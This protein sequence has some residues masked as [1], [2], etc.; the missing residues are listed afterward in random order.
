M[1]SEGDLVG[2]TDMERE[3]RRDWWLALLA[4]GEALN[5]EFVAS[6]RT[7]QHK[8]SDIMTAPVITV[9]ETAPLAEVAGLLAAH[10][11]KRTPVIRDGRIVGIVSRAD[12]LRTLVKE[13]GRT[14]LPRAPRPPA[15]KSNG[16]ARAP[17]G[18]GV[19]E[20]KAGPLLAADLRALGD[21]FKRRELQQ[22]EEARRAAIE[23]SRRK[24][25]ELLDQRLSDATWRRTLH[26]ARQIAENGGKEFMLLRFPSELC[27]DGGRAVNVPDPDWPKTL[28]GEAAE[29]YALWQRDLMP[30][31]FKLGAWVL[32]FPGGVPGDIGLFLSWHE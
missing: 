27:S 10:R 19:A 8:A 3:A 16:A 20:A 26:N 25:K 18:N 21:D 23:E 12:L 24:V 11:I 1:V 7:M 5:P 31:G 17:T 2:R 4:E 22:Q 9:G 28:R 15:S 13:P 32:E 14:V 6:L 30:N 29:L